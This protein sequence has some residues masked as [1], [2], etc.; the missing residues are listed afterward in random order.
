[1]LFPHPSFFHHYLRCHPRVTYRSLLS[2]PFA[3]PP[4]NSLAPISQLLSLQWLADSLSLLPLFCA[5]APFIFNRLRT[6]CA[7]HGGWGWCPSFLRL[8]ATRSVLPAS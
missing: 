5:G 4:V 3:T 1:M 6:L 2:L 7:K 8:C